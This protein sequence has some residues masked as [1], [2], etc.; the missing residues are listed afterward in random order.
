MS[1]ILMA[2]IATVLVL[3]AAS[4]EPPPGEGQVSRPESFASSPGQADIPYEDADTDTTKSTTGRSSQVAFTNQRFAVVYVRLRLNNGE[5]RNVR[6]P[7]G[8]SYIL[9]VYD[10][11]AVCMCWH[12]VKP[13]QQCLLPDPVAVPANT[14]FQFGQVVGFRRCN[15]NF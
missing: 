10:D 2:S 13:V 15:G 12:D 14:Q 6:I 7:R 11:S 5:I 1:R 4:A 3:S 8:L 9:P